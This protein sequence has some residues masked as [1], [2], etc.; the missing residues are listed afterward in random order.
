M[1]TLSID[2]LCQDGMPP[3]L[4]QE[5]RLS[6]TQ[7]DLDLLRFRLR[8]RR[9]LFEVDEVRCDG[10]EGRLVL[11]WTGEVEGRRGG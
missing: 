7:D 9:M 2:V 5:Q 1:I 4:R 8:K 6:A 10:E 11:R 3:P